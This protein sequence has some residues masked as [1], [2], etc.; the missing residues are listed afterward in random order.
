MRDK[1]TMPVHLLHAHQLLCFGITS[2]ALE[3]K[4]ESD[5]PVMT[6]AAAFL[7]FKGAAPASA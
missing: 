3:G 2:G 5:I 7:R 4:P 1:C 6:S